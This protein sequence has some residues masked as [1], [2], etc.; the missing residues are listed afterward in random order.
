MTLK[1]KKLL[2]VGVAMASNLN[3]KLQ[4]KPDTVLAFVTSLAEATE[5]APAAFGRVA[6]GG[7]V[8]IVYPKGTS[9]VRTDVNR[10]ILWEALKPTGWRPVRQISLDETWSA[11]RFRPEA[12]VGK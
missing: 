1:G 8:W 11:I 10:D 6:G 7:L 2:R 5:M 12:E 4:L 3:S 9:K